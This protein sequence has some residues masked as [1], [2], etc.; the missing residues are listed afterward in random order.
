MVVKSMV[1]YMVSKVIHTGKSKIKR[2]LFYV[3]R[4]PKISC[5]TIDQRKM[6]KLE[7]HVLKC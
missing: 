1:K 2:F 3:A 5:G 4:S 7:E 6:D